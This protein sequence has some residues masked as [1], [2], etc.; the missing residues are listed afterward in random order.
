MSASS[1]T[2][3]AVAR[4]QHELEILKLSLSLLR[5]VLRAQL[6]AAH[7]CF[8]RFERFRRAVSSH[9]EVE[10][11]PSSWVQTYKSICDGPSMIRTCV[12]TAIRRGGAARARA[13]SRGRACRAR[14]PGGRRGC[15]GRL[16]VARRTSASE[17]FAHLAPRRCRA[18]SR[19]R[20]R[21][22]TLLA[23]RGARRRAARAACRRRAAKRTESGPPLGVVAGAVED[24]HAAGA[25]HGDEAREQVDELAPVGEGAGVEQVV[26]VEEVEASAQPS[27][28]RAGGALRRGAAAAAT[29]TLSDST[30]PERAGSR[31][32]TSQ[33]RARAG[34]APC[35]RRRRRA[36][37]RRR[38][39]SSHIERLAPR[40]PR[41]RPRGRRP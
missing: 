18:R 3:V 20:R 2:G 6:R 33:L 21:S 40:R 26:A 31:R 41:R 34:A 38:G 27:A 36:R 8:P 28:R 37:R 32:A 10:V 1:A 16:E 39:R 35:P 5:R 13:A 30:A 23:R 17:R 7:V 12:R 11:E 14:P 9:P 15:V 19:P 22:A 25:L 29:L 4:L 24:E